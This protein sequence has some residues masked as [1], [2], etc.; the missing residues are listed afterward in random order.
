[1][2]RIELCENGIYAVWQVCDDLRL[3]LL[4]FSAQ[5]CPENEMPEEGFYA[6]EVQ[7]TGGKL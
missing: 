2:N 7:V 4:H 1:M 3:Q 6:L 5:A